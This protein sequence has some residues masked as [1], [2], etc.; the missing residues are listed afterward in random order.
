MPGRSSWLPLLAL[1]PLLFFLDRPVA[2]DDPL[3]LR[4]AEAIRHD[5]LRPLAGTVNWFGTPQ[6]VWDVVKNGPA[7]SYWLAAVQA[8]GLTSERALH[9]ALLP[10]AVAAVLAGARLARR[11]ARGSP[12]ATALWVASPA[13]LLSAAT[14]MVDVP[15]MALALWGV[16]GW[17]EGVDDDRAGR[18]RLGALLI[19]LAIVVK[20]TALV[21]V[22]V[23]A[24]YVLLRRPPRSRGRSL[25]ALSPAAAPL[26]AWTALN[27]VTDGRAHAVDSLFVGGGV[28]VPLPGLLAQ[29]TIA[30]PVFVVATGVFPIAFLGVARRRPGGR[31]VL[32]LAALLGVGAG[33]AVSTVWSHL[34]AAI[35]AA[36]MPLAAAGVCALVLAVGDGW[37]ALRA[38]DPD[39]AF[40]VAW[41]VLQALFAW[42]WAWSAAARHLL[43][44]FPPL[45]LLLVRAAPRSRALAAATVVAL[46]L[47]TVLLRS[48]TA[49]ADFHR[50][51][52]PVI[53]RELASAGVRGRVL[54]AWSFQYYGERAGLARL[55]LLAPELRP[56]DVVLNPYFAANS[57]MPPAL[58]ARLEP[59]RTER[60]PAPLL[61]LQ[62]VSVG[63]G[64]YSSVWG[65]LPFW[66][67]ETVEG[68]NVWRVARDAP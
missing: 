10:F 22:A 18:C 12:W 24:V 36:V 32:A 3:F 27:L 9:L 60:G 7:L 15:A 38:R 48:D 56:G 43:F 55:D 34:P 1:L 30:L 39:T 23:V 31:V 11:F 51:R 68:V 52:L 35:S 21:A 62:T 65:P 42:F 5:P 4:L 2:I 46:A 47:A 13:F 6:P 37:R 66:I 28:L 26:A 14:L 29:R 45:A 17:V 20:Y 8:L 44:L 64:F 53:A 16:V 33:A 54:G 59:V 57:A 67:G 19:G 49:A 25:L 58:K 50:E 40:L 41:V 61:R 63:A